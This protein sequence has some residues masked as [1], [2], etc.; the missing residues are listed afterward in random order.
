MTHRNTRLECACGYVGRVRY[1][2]LPPERCPACEIR[3]YQQLELVLERSQPQTEA[4]AGWSHL[5]LE[6]KE[7]V[8]RYIATLL[9]EQLRLF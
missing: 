4:P 8:E 1:T 7:R 6:Q 3:A 9:A 2:H 5:S